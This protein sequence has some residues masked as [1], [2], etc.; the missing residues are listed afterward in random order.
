MSFESQAIANLIEA[1]SQKA[2]LIR[3]N[4]MKNPAEALCLVVSLVDQ[5]TCIVWMYQI[6]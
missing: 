5:L 6:T 3:P 2:K 1:Q 4:G